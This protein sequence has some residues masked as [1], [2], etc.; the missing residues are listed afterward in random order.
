[1]T[2]ETDAEI[3]KKS[4]AKAAD[5]AKDL[6]KGADQQT[7]VASAQ[8]VTAHKLEDLSADLAKSAADADKNL[9]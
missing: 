6:R 3:L 9:Q 8:H 7:A 5:L 2:A 4:S 1:M